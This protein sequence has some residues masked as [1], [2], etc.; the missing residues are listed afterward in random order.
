LTIN[1][2]NYVNIDECIDNN[3]KNNKILY[4]KRTP[5]RTVLLRNN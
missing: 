5:K 1:K 3:G 4:R 2:K